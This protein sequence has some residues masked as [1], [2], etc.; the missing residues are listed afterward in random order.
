MLSTQEAATFVRALPEGLFFGSRG[1][2]LM[3]PSTSRGSREAPGYLRAKLPAFVRPSYWYDMYRP[4][5]VDYSAIDRNR[6]LWRASVDG[7]RARFRDD[8]AVVHDYR[9]FFAFD[10]GSGALRWANQLPSDAVGSADTGGSIL[11]ATASGEL[12]AFDVG[13]GARSYQA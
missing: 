13:T 3:A 10:A 7:D 1:V 4:E 8:V 6:I 11:F 9:F 5:Q 12:G 2:F